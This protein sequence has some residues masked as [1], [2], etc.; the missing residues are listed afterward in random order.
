MLLHVGN[1]G[2]D[3]EFRNNR[4]NLSQIKNE[5]NMCTKKKPKQPIRRCGKKTT[6]GKKININIHMT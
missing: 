6:K 5:N 2:D 1:T 4:D 3:T